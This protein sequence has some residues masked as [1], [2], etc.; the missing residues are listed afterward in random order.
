MYT[1]IFLNFRFPRNPERS[2]W[3]MYGSRF[4]QDPCTAQRGRLCLNNFQGFE[5]VF[6]KFSSNTLK[7]DAVS[8]CIHG[9]FNEP[10]SLRGYQTIALRSNAPRQKRL[11][12][13]APTN[14]SRQMRFPTNALPSICACLRFYFFFNISPRPTWAK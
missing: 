2:C 14:A 12:Q 10:S 9:Y 3:D 11:D 5:Y 8:I 4:R 7:R 13:S 1:V 6:N